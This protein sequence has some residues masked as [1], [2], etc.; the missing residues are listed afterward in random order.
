MARIN[1]I[2]YQTNSLG[3]KELNLIIQVEVVNKYSILKLQKEAPHGLKL[4]RYPIGQS[5]SVVTSVQKE[6]QAFDEILTFYD[7]KPPKESQFH[8]SNLLYLLRESE[9]YKQYLFA[10][11]NRDRVLLNRLNL[12]NILQ[13]KPPTDFSITLT[14]KKDS[15]FKYRFLDDN[16]FKDEILQVIVDKLKA[17]NHT[18][19]DFKHLDSRSSDYVLKTKLASTMAKVILRYLSQETIVLSN[20]DNQEPPFSVTNNQ[21]EFIYKVL[22]HFGLYTVKDAAKRKSDTDFHESIRKLIARSDNH[23]IIKT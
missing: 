23:D 20:K 10:A 2:S 15:E 7:L 5:D 11:T 6:I 16:Q 13:S 18:S 12:L 1:T 3:N 21:G 22:N 17:L 19:E 14:D 8:G 4:I 9:I